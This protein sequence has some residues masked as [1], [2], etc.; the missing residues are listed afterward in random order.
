MESLKDKD[1]DKWFAGYLKENP[2]Y[3]KEAVKEEVKKE[4]LTNGQRDVDRPTPDKGGAAGGGKSF[5][6]GQQNSMNPQEAVAEGR[7]LGYSWR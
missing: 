7:K 2:E 3:A 1:I 6:P 5:K 4:P